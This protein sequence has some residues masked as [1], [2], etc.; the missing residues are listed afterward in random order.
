MEEHQI[1]FSLIGLANSLEKNEDCV[2][3]FLQSFQENNQLRD[4][5]PEVIFAIGWSSGTILEAS[6]K[7]QSLIREC[8]P[9]FDKI[10]VP[11]INY[12]DPEQALTDLKEYLDKLIV[13]IKE[14]AK[15]D[16]K[17]TKII[18]KDQDLKNWLAS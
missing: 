5:A 7:I 9:G 2:D 4:Y 11:D 8:C 18:I 16:I 15:E 1:P 10:P 6:L 14:L 13:V 17:D 12:Q 3:R